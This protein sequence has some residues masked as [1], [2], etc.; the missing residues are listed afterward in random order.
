[1][2][3]V[4][5]HEQRGSYPVAKLC[6]L[7]S[8]SKSGYHAWKN[9]PPSVRELENVRLETHIRAI[10]AESG[11]TYG[12]PRVHRE[13]IPEL[14]PVEH[15]WDDLREKHFHNHVLDSLDALENHLVTAFLAYENNA[16]CVASIT[17]WQWIINAL[18]NYKWN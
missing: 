3:Y 10:H 18:Q 2:K 9:R 13:L 8:V 16:K 11:G 5:I 6:E 12:S 1:V 17:E 7:L 15:I 4:W 14:N